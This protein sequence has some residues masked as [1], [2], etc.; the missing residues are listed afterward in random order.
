VIFDL[1]FERKGGERDV[2]FLDGA[3]FLLDPV[4]ELPKVFML[5]TRGATRV[6]FFHKSSW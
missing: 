3:G 4:M 6:K 5:S 2:V 1:P